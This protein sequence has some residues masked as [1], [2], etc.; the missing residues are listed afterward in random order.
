[1]EVRIEGTAACEARLALALLKGLSRARL[2][3][4]LRAS[5][6]PEGVFPA[7]GRERTVRS[8]SPAEEA[9]LDRDLGPEI[10]GQLK[11][12]ALVESYVCA[13][14]DAQYPALL[15]EIN[16]PPLVLFWRGDI[17]VAARPAVAVVGSRKC[18]HSG[19]LVAERLGRAL[20]GEGLVVVSGLARGIDTAAHR[21]ALEA[22]GV[23][24]AVL[25][26]GVDVCYPAENRK[27]LAEILERGAALSE[28]PLG[29]APLRQNFPLRNRIVSGLSLGVVVVE[30]GEGS[31]A[32]VTVEH[33]LM[34]GREVFA[35][36]G[37]TTLN[38][39]I[40]SNR[41]LKEGAKLVTKVEDILEELG[42]QVREGLE[43]LPRTPVEREG[44]S[45]EEERML[46]NLSHVPKNVDEICS[47]TGMKTA[48]VLSLLLSLELKGLVRQ[49]PGDLFLRN[50][51]ALSPRRP[52]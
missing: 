48:D 39:T 40:S 25:G 13:W 24:V 9:L 16:Y 33:A 8:P 21:G 52:E 5:G 47:Q 38:S 50:P 1:M 41:L 23:T 45:C 17:S 43:P 6:T 44:V 3:E 14:T 49:E 46:Q 35:V 26:S 29:T 12:G 2:L 18:S 20:A 30:A 34:Q 11:L 31:G 19:R 10:A 28:F 7:P 37:D 32:L 27:L 36:P 42:A 4:I 51:G 15:R 22:G